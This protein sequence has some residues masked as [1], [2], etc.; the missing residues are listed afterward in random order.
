[1][2]NYKKIM[3]LKDYDHDKIMLIF[4]YVYTGAQCCIALRNF[5]EAIQWCDEGLKV[6]PTDKKLQELRASADKHKV[7][8][9]LSS[10]DFELK[11]LKGGCNCI[12]GICL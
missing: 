10:A 12:V 11:N 2:R 8:S 4:V 7:Q 1:M 6:H 5:S 3:M 9:L